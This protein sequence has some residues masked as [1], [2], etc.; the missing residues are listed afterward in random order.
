MYPTVRASS[1]LALRITP[2]PVLLLSSPSLLIFLA[3]LRRH[4]R[5]GGQSISHVPRGRGGADDRRLSK[6]GVNCWSET[7]G[8]HRGHV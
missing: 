2:C 5:D 1:R 6:A 7:E 4:R 8:R 3:T